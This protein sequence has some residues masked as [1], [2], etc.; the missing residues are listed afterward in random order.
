MTK[1]HTTTRKIAAIITAALFIFACLALI[2]PSY[3]AESSVTVASTDEFLSALRDTSVTNIDI[4]TSSVYIDEEIAIDRAVTINGLGAEL[5]FGTD[6]ALLVQ[7]GGALILSK[8]RIVDNHDYAI[9]SYGKL[10]FGESVVIDGTHGI[11]LYPGSSLTSNNNPV[12]ALSDVKTAVAISA[13]GSAISVGDIHLAQPSGDGTLIRLEGLSGSVEFVDKIRLECAEGD[14]ILCTEATCPSV[15]FDK[16]STVTI[17]SPNAGST[18]N[19]AAVDIAN[20]ALTIGDGSQL[21]LDGSKC[22]ISASSMTVGNNVK[23][24][25]SCSASSDGSAEGKKAAAMCVGGYLST[26]SGTEISIGASSSASCNG[27]FAGIGIQFGQKNSF[28]MRGSGAQYCAIYSP[29]AISFGAQSS[30][31]I[32]STK[33]GIINAGGLTF[34][35]K[36]NIDI[37]GIGSVAVN[38]SGAGSA[39][40]LR[41]EENCTA[42]ISSASTALY[43]R[44]EITVDKGCDITLDSKSSPAI[45]LDAS[46]ATGTISAQD[47]ASVKAISGG[48]CGI[49][50]ISGSLTVATSASVYAGGERGVHITSGNITVESGGGLFAEGK[51]HSAISVEKGDITLGKG[52]RLDAQGAKYGIELL[53]SGNL[54]V[55][56]VDAFDVRGIKERALYISN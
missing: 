2:S 34:G 54:T 48:E 27:I 39:G 37:S 20:G 18:T 47:S 24:D 6:S 8:A 22:A 50:C 4:N 51:A 45:L 56:T 35:D 11:M 31:S 15:S 36:C 33:N 12:A 7:S 38:C 52:T 1:T 49:R 21:K 32:R 5:H 44:G 23:L 13:G 28:L 10:I 3:S 30:I 16:N 26:G 55:G 19:P 29:S 46:G 41:F 53:Q 9:Y 14:A 42:T 43:S 17:S 25:L 40:A